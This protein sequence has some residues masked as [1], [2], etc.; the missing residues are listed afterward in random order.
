[1]RYEIYY[2][3]QSILIVLKSKRSSDIQVKWKYSWLLCELC[4][5]QNT[6]CIFVFSRPVCN[7]T[8]VLRGSHCYDDWQEQVTLHF[9]KMK[10]TLF[11]HKSQPAPAAASEDRRTIW[12]NSSGK[13]AIWPFLFISSL[14]LCFSN[15]MCHT[16]FIVSQSISIWTTRIWCQK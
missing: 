12:L 10:Q 9:I 7:S 5:C 1:M 4:S 2:V 13:Y 8:W 15:H 6:I 16:R 11:G 14:Q 3:V